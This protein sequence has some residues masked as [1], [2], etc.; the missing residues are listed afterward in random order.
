MAKYFFE[1]YASR[2]MSLSMLAAWARENVITRYGSSRPLTKSRIERILKNEFYLGT[3]R[4]KGRLYKGNYEPLIGK[5]L[6]DDVKLAFKVHNKPMSKAKRFAFSNLMVCADCG[7]KI[8]AEIKKGKY[9]YYHCTGMRGGNHKVYVPEPEI[10]GQFADKL[11]PLVL[12][13]DQVYE[14]MKELERQYSVKSKM[15]KSEL[16]RIQRRI[17]QIQTWKEKSYI[18]KLEEKISEDHWLKLNEK[19]D[20][21]LFRLKA[22]LQAHDGDF[23]SKIITAGK[24][25]ELAQRLPDLWIK[26]NNYEKRKLV[27]LIYSN[28]ILN[29][30]TLCTT[31]RKPFRFIAEGGQ[32]NKKLGDRDSNPDT[33]VQSHVSC[34]WTIAQ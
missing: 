9:T 4:W 26:Q 1:K 27:D 5:Q 20:D 33:M 2:E 24:I 22:K 8:T 13:H 7:C 16:S 19:W 6:F 11:G 31:Y 15:N 23:G 29:G 25:L 17:S 18:D 21:E 28:C 34:R 14:I 12:T 30:R 32:T 10:V 3:F